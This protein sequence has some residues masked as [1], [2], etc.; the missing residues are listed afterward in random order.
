MRGTLVVSLIGWSDSGK[1]SLVV[2]AIEECVRRGI[3]CAAAKCS[4]HTG[5]FEL[6]GKDSARYREAGASPVAY[7]GTGPG[8]QTACFVPTPIEPGREWLESLFPE[9]ILIFV[10]GLEVEGAI[11]VLV[12]KEGMALKRPLAWSDI[13][14]SGNN[15]HAIQAIGSGKKVI[16]PGDAKSLVDIVEESWIGK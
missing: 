12:D 6:E 10:E 1:T 14:V 2:R 16:S 7:I 5:D 13:L 4:H 3:E 11:N 8:G 15:E 9:S